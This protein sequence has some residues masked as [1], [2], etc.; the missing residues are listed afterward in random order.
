MRWEGGIKQQQCSGYFQ[1]LGKF[2]VGTSAKR[3]RSGLCSAAAFS[4]LPR[5]D[6]EV[7]LSP[8]FSGRGNSGLGS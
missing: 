7:G 8:L 4:N 2:H 5:A 3:D 1:S 6:R